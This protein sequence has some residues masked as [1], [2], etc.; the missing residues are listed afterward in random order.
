MRA[1]NEWYARCNAHED[2]VCFFYFCGHGLHKQ[3][4][5]LLPEDFALSKQMGST[6]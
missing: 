3:N 6:P 1:F 2:N 5:Y 4:T